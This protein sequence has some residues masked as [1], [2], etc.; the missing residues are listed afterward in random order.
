MG[1]I[2]IIGA[3]AQEVHK[4]KAH[5]TQVSVRNYASME[6]YQGILMGREAVVVQSGIGKV[7]AAVCAQILADV[8][9]V[10]AI[11][12]TG[13]AGSLDKD[14]NIG[15]IVISTDVVEH[16]MDVTPLGYRKGQ[17]PGM[18]LFYFEADEKLRELAVKVCR[19]VNPDIRVFEGRI[20]SGDQFISGKDVKDAIVGN[21]GGCATEMEGAAIGHTAVLNGIPFLVIRAISDKADDSAHMDY[22]AFE[23]MAIEHSVK[24]MEG[25]LMEL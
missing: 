4:L 2:G 10:S 5:M 13:V 7:N 19:K 21:F 18:D 8:F 9:E 17:I 20:N 22:G 14:I 23:M 3:M 1:R 12:N 24:L 16:D 11:V 15:D 25:M 6:F